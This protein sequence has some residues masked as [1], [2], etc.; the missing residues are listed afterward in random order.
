MRE[1]HSELTWKEVRASEASPTD[2][3]LLRAGTH[4]HAPACI[5]ETLTNLDTGELICYNAPLYGK[6]EVGPKSGQSFDEPEYAAGIPPCYWGDAAEGLPPPPRLKRN[7]VPPPPPPRPKVPK[8]N[9]R[10]ALVYGVALGV[11]G[12][13]FPAVLPHATPCGVAA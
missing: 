2:V 7:P 4:C 9:T 6:G 10:L 13:A 8:P 3:L 12:T 11:A 5:N 1:R